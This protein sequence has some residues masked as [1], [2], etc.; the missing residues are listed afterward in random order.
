[1]NTHF[2]AALRIVAEAGSL[3]AAARQLNL[4]I[5]SVSEQIRVL[6]RDLDAP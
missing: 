5:A 6:E 2:L 3:A 1:M 4:A